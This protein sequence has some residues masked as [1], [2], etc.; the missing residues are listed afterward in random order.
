M[1]RTTICMTCSLALTAGAAW[2][3][4]HGT[5]HFNRI[6]SFPVVTNMAEGEDTSRETSPEIID[7]TADGMTLVYTDSPLEALGR[8]DITDPANPKPLGN[9]ALD[10]EPTSV[11]VPAAHAIVG[12]NTSASYTEPSGYIASIDVASGTEANRCDLGGQPDSV[13]VAPDNSFVAIA[14]ENERDEDLGDGRTGQLPGGFLVMVGLTEDGVL[15]CETLSSVDLAGLADVS[16]EDPEPE[17]VSINSLGETVV[18]LQENNHLMVVSR[19]GTVLSHF[20]AGAV[21][22]ENID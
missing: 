6:A 15:D 7:V 4:G 17:Y 22:L 2:A 8:I 11:V 14:I 9:I 19:D 18:T 10:G 20:S 3:D 13:A 5:K 12:V 21:D 1:T 16:P